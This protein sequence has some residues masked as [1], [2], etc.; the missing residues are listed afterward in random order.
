MWQLILG[1]VLGLVGGSLEKVFEFKMVKLKA[2]ERALERAHDLEAM[3]L[4]SELTTR[5]IKIEGEIKVGQMDA[6]AFKENLTAAHQSMIPIGQKLTDTQLSW[7]VA[8]E[9]FCKMIR[10]LT[11]T[12]YQVFLAAVFGW[13][14]WNLAQQGQQVFTSDEFKTMFREMVYSVI[15]IAETTLFWWYGIRRMSKKLAD[16]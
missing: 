4:E 6:E 5:E 13:A 11:T 1:P 7:V 3:R 16:Q 9:V 2:E 15:G 8:V 12:M 14:A 10:P